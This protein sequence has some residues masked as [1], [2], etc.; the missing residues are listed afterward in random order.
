MITSCLGRKVGNA[1]WWLVQWWGDW[2]RHTSTLCAC[3]G[4]KV[5]LIEL[6]L[7]QWGSVCVCGV[8]SIEHTPPSGMCPYWS[9]TSSTCYERGKCACGL[10]N[11]IQL[12]IIIQKHQMTSVTTGEQLSISCITMLWASNIIT[13]T[14]GNGFANAN[15][16][17]N[18]CMTSWSSPDR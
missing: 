3:G 1:G 6:G 14:F 16:Y 10:R 15:T 12:T 13:R 11:R 7:S 9:V 8:G 17:T 18:T 4:S 5:W 2:E